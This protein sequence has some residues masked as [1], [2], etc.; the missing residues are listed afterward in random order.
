[1]KVFAC[2]PEWAA[3]TQE[4]GGDNVE[5]FTAISP[6]ENPE[7]V[8]ATPALISALSQADLLVCTGGGFEDS[9]LNPALSRAQNP[10]LGKGKPG[11]FYASQFVKLMEDHDEKPAAKGG[12]GHSHGAAKSGH[13]HGEGNPHIQ[14]DPRRVRTVAGQLGRRMI[15]VDPS[16]KA[17]YGDRTKAFLQNFAALIKELEKKAKPLDH[18]HVI[19]QHEHS[20]YL[21]DWLGLEISGIVEP[22]VGVPPGPADLARIVEVAQKSKAK[23]VIHAAY[24]DPRP[25]QFVTE[26]V[27]IPLVKLPF[28][29]GGTEDAKTLTDFYRASVDR[30]LDGLAGRDRN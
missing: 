22:E 6:T 28:T 13:A 16:G 1:M 10:K 9:W 25:S 27:K 24:E 11:A 21:L 3:L 15:E 18:V 7:Q 29:V 23:F 20:N 8:S 2:L 5:I 14:G 17:L 26:R 19:V 4:L 12:H 30:L